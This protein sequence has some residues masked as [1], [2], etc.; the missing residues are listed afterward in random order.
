M[1][2]NY[3]GE[4]TDGPFGDTKVYDARNGSELWRF[5]TIAK[6]GDPGYKDSWLN[7]SWKQPRGGVNVWG[8]YFSVD[9]Q[10][11]L[12]FMP[13]GGPAGNYYG[14]DRPGNN[15]YGNSL[16][17][18]N[19]ITGKYVWHFQVVHHDLWD[20]DLSCSAKLARREEG[21]QDDSRARANK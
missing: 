12:L 21:W 18:V 7:D 14:G 9:E 10:R 20:T 6:P 17:A 15:L 13:V 11:D 5:K 2:G 8:W 19:A 16:V 3:N 1:I 4:R